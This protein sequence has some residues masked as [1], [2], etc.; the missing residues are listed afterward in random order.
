M[1]CFIAPA[2]EAAVLTITKKVI[3]K[4]KKEIIELDTENMDSHE[5]EVH[6]RISMTTKIGWLTKMLWGGSFLLLIEHIWHGEVVLW[7]PFLTAMGN[8]KET[9]QMF[10]EIATAGVSMAVLVTVVWAVMVSIVNIKESSLL[11]DG[12]AGN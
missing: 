9:A 3:E 2:V 1:A 6:S 5:S 4:R 10:H 8:V 12:T 11:K 7:P